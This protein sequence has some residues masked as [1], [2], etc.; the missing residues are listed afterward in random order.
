MGF[1]GQER[2]VTNTGTGI[3][4]FSRF[5]GDVGGLDKGGEES[6]DELDVCVLSTCW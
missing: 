2:D 1:N 3:V 6:S 5:L 4:T